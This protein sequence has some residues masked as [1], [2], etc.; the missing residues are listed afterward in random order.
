MTFCNSVSPTPNTFYNLKTLRKLLCRQFD[1][2]Q[3]VR[4]QCSHNQFDNI[5]FNA[6]FANS[7]SS[8][9]ALSSQPVLPYVDP[10]AWHRQASSPHHQIVSTIGHFRPQNHLFPESLWCPLSTHPPQLSRYLTTITEIQPQSTLLLR[11][12]YIV[13]NFYKSRIC[14]V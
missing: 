11:R 6:L 7:V 3:Q 10:K 13:K 14:R 8:I 12:S 4:W 1:F 5:H 2:P 9:I